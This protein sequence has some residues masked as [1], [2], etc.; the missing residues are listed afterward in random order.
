VKRDEENSDACEIV[1]LTPKHS[2][3]ADISHKNH[4]RRTIT[5]HC[6]L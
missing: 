6:T 2:T 5:T 4:E 1:L 3:I